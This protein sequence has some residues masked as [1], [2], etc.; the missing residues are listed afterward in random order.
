MQQRLKAAAR[1][2]GAQ[3][4]A[5]Q[6]FHQLLVTV[7]NARSALHASFGRESLAALTGA[8]ERKGFLPIALCV[9]CYP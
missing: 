2:A 6:F 1:V 7:N 5:A 3:V 8:L 9:P 4:I